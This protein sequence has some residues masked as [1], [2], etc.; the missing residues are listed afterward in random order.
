MFP[1]FDLEKI[2]FAA[3]AETFKRAV[4]LYEKGK[5]KEFEESPGGYSAAVEGGHLYHVLVEA[6]RFGHGQCDC[7]MGQN[8]YVC[9]H[10]V[11]VY[12]ILRGKPIREKEKK[13]QEGPICSEKL[14]KLSKLE[15]AGIKK[16][17]SAA[18]KYIK[19]YN[20]SSRIWF[21]YQGSLCEGCNRLSAIVSE[22]PV[23]MDTAKLL[24]DLL[25]RLDKKLCEGGV[26]D[27]EGTVGG[28]IEEV[29]EVLR[30]Y[31]TLDPACSRPFEVLKNRE[32]CFGWEE[33]LVKL[34][35]R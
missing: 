24:V 23:S 19:P 18:A 11:A 22:L 26:D 29:V 30:Q 2:K 35:N 9:K 4:D 10:M 7:Y 6:R 1:N 28:F 33:P 5:I 3:D 16:S 31:F 15:L 13:I 32:T 25:L 17:I 21:A 34:V 20:G 12:A 27:S 14:G 8:D